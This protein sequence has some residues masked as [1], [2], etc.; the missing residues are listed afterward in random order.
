[1]ATCG[2]WIFLPQS[3][4]L[5]A[6]L[7]GLHRS[8]A[9]D[10]VKN[11]LSRELAVLL[12]FQASWL[13]GTVEIRHERN[14]MS[15]QTTDSYRLAWPNEH[16]MLWKIPGKCRC[17]YQN[18]LAQGWSEADDSDAVIDWR[19]WRSITSAIPINASAVPV[20]SRPASSS[21]LAAARC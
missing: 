16:R 20:S 21:V 5:I 19:S 11:A 18:N 10:Q 4:Q 7:A 9:A 6:V 3:P 17:C 2:P 1:M 13:D 8:Q 14:S 12:P 15:S